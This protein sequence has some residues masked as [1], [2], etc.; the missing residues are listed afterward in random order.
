MSKYSYPFAYV[1][2]LGTGAVLIYLLFWAL[3]PGVILLLWLTPSILVGLWI[4]ASGLWS[5]QRAKRNERN[6]SSR[7][8]ML[9]PVQTPQPPGE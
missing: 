1:L 8:L 2:L 7:I 6:R 9:A 3:S 4:A 5:R